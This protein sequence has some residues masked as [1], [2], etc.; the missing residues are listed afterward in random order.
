MPAAIAIPAIATVAGA[1]VNAVASHLAQRSAQSQA[2]RN[3]ADLQRQID[4]NMAQQAA[5]RTGVENS[6]GYQQMLAAAQGPQTSTMNSTSNQVTTQD[7]GKQQGTLDEAM[8]AAKNS[9]Q[10]ANVLQAQELEALNR[11]IAGQQQAQNRNI[12]NIAASRGVDPRVARLGMDQGINNQRL[13]AELGIAQQ[14]RENTRQAWGDVNA[15][16]QN[17]KTTRTKGSQSST[18]VGGPNIGGY[19]G[20]LGITRPEDR[21][22]VQRQA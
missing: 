5:W 20:L 8:N 22:V 21:P 6:P 3:Y 16:L 2:D 15:L 10:T 18:S 7:F 12:Q 11:N 17:Y 9:V 4:A 14:G 1:G 13:N 19:L